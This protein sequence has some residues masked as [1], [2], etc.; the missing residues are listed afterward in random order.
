[1]RQADFYEEPAWI[2]VKHLSQFSAG[3]P[4]FSI[5]ERG[6]DVLAKTR[7]QERALTTLGVMFA[8]G[9][10]YILVDPGTIRCS[11]QS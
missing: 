10:N 3:G 8:S 11:L 2:L 9:K 6:R 4:G 5:S 7:G 1:M